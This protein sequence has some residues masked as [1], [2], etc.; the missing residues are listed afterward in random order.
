[1]AKAT[2]GDVVKK[3]VGVPGEMLGIVYDLLD[4]LTG[5]HGE[6]WATEIKLLFRQG[7][8]KVLLKFLGKVQVSGVDKFV[9]ADCF[10][11]GNDQGVKFV[12]FGSNF[13]T[14]LLGKVE[15]GVSQAELTCYELLEASVDGPIR[16]ELGDKFEAFL[17]DLWALLA[18]QPNGEEPNGRDRML[19]T[20]GRANILY[21]Y[22]SAVGVGWGSDG[23]SVGAYS[24]ESPAGWG[25]GSRVFSRDS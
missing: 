5:E 17:A 22:G 9:A 15:E 23:W 19:F 18:Q 4:R 24:V 7:L 8:P 20:D 14:H 6:R 10:K 11:K 3:L 16:A 1:M 12:G 2:L 13:E 25:A 21:M